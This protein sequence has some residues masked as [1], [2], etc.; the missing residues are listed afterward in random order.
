MSEVMLGRYEVRTDEVR[1]LPRVS[2]D[3]NNSNYV[4]IVTPEYFE[5]KEI[6]EKK[7]KRNDSRLPCLGNL[8]MHMKYSY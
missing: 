4:K 5:E 6:V 2:K 3:R 7:I 8:D 1:S